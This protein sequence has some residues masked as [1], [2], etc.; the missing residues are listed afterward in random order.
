MVLGALWGFLGGC[1]A[2]HPNVMCYAANTQ[3]LG[4]FAESASTGVIKFSCLSIVPMRGNKGRQRVAPY[5]QRIILER[6]KFDVD[7]FGSPTS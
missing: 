5:H 7:K 4:T 2:C 6:D 3:A 1:L